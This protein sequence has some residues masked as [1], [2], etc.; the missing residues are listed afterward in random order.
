ME[1]KSKHFWFKKE[2]MVI[3]NFVKE[4]DIPLFSE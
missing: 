4:D 2:K 1:T 3:F